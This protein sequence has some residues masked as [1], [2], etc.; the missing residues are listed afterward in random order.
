MG[1]LPELSTNPREHVELAS[2]SPS[3]LEEKLLNRM[4]GYVLVRTLSA[5]LC[6]V[7]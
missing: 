3:C 2:F 6:L 5:H 7:S 1:Q 4:P